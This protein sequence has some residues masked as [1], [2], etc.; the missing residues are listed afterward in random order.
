MI[1]LNDVE[2]TYDNGTK[3][4]K[5]I[6]LTIEDGEFVFLVGASGSGKTSII[7]LLTSELK[8]TAGT[9]SGGWGTAQAAMTG[10][11]RAAEGS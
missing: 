8:P 2:L 4:L 1:Q 11:S 6:T 3:A 10:P 5:G 7:K 9:M